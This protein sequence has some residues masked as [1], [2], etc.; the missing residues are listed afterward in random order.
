MGGIVS[1][2]FGLFWDPAYVYVYFRLRRED[3]DEI[4]WDNEVPPLAL[5]TANEL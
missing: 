4:D 5:L 3:D 1:V 2:L